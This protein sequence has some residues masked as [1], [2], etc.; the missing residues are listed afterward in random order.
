MDLGFDVGLARDYHPDGARRTRVGDG[1]LIWMLGPER[2]SVGRAEDH[3]GSGSRRQWGW[4]PP[5]L[6]VTGGDNSSLG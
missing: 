4:W 6:V 2:Q 5:G 3:K 1:A